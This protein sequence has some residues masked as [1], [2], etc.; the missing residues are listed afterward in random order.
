MKELS[1]LFWILTAVF[2]GTAALT[3]CDDDDDDKDRDGG[4]SIIAGTYNGDLAAKVTTIDCN[5]EGKYDFI[6]NKQQDTD[7][8]VTVVLPE[9]SYTTPGMQK[10]QTIPAI[11]VTDVDVKRSIS[12]NNVYVIEEDNFTVTIDGVV[13]YGTIQGT[14][15]G[16]DIQVNYSLRPGKMPMVINFTFSGKKK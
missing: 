8:D 1:K 15:T 2:I 5:I 4:A 3:S 12:D 9:C 7:D 16:F 10:P 13:Y 14:V 6:I 11:T